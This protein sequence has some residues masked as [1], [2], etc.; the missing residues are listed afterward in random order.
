MKVFCPNCKMNVNVGSKLVRPATDS[1]A[2]YDDCCELC[3]LDDHYLWEPEEF[4]GEYINELGGYV[5]G[6]GGDIMLPNAPNGLSV[7]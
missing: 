7:N 1:P 3:G 6:S 2:E 4:D 5:E